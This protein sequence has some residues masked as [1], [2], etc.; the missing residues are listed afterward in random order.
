[1][2]KKIIIFIIIIVITWACGIVFY[3]LQVEQN[4]EI[5]LNVNE[6]I[7]NNIDNIEKNNIINDTIT[8]NLFNSAELGK[9]GGIEIN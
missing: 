3:K 1:M 6:N 5:K 9:W 7:E 4:K 8:I 2:S